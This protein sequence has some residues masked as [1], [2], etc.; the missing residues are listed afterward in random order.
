ML[1]VNIDTTYHLQFKIDV[2]TIIYYESQI[3]RLL[4]GQYLQAEYFISFLK[5]NKTHIFTC[6]NVQYNTPLRATINIAKVPK[7]INCV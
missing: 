4:K 5:F 1:N 3:R 6:C 2:L 7:I